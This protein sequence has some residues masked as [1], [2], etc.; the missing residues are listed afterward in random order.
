MAYIKNKN[1]SFDWDASMQFLQKYWIVILGLII[2]VPWIQNYLE[3]MKTKNQND[4]L[5]NDVEKIETKKAVEKEIKLLDNKNPLTQKQKRLKITGSSELWAASEKLASDFGFAIQDSGDWWDFA[6]PRK[7][8]ENDESIRNTL[9][10]YRNYFS[11]LEKLYFQ[12]DTDSRSLRADILKYLD[13]SELVLV[14]KG[15][16]I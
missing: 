12:V 5:E 7:W 14:R 6:K 11:I 15:L 8:T 2:A 13:K 3:E 10:K 16:K 4:K 1:N 9:L